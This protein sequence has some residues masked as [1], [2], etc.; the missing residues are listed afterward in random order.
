MVEEGSPKAAVPIFSG[1]P[2][3]ACRMRVSHTHNLE[4]RSVSKGSEPTDTQKRFIEVKLTTSNPERFETEIQSLA[5]GDP[6]V[7]YRP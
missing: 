4:L 3:L 2:A 7:L 5:G 1:Y 6:E